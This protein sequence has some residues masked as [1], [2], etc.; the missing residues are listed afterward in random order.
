VE[1]T[2]PDAGNDLEY[3]IRSGNSLGTFGIN[4][5]D[6]GS[7]FVANANA[8]DF[9]QQASYNLSVVLTDGSLETLIQVTVYIN[10]L[11]DVEIT[12]L[13]GNVTMR[14]RGGEIIIITGK[15][16]GPTSAKR[17]VPNITATY[18]T[19]FAT[20]CIIIQRNVK[21][22]CLSSQ[23]IGLGHR[24]IITVNGQSSP[25]SQQT[26]RY[27]QPSIIDVSTAAPLSTQGGENI[28]I[29]ADD[30]GPKG[31]FVKLVYAQ[32]VWAEQLWYRSSCQV[33]IAHRA[34]VCVSVVGIGKNLVSR[35]EVGEQFSTFS[36]IEI[37]Y[38][39]PQIYALGGATLMDTGGGE[40]VTI[41]GINF[42][43][44]RIFWELPPP[45]GQGLAPPQPERV[46]A[47]YGPQD[48][49]RQ[50][51][52][53]HCQVEHAHDEVK[54]I[55]TAGVG[56]NHRWVIQIGTGTDVQ[57]SPES[58]NTSAYKRPAISEI[59]GPG[60]TGGSTAGGQDFW[61]HGDNLGPS[62]TARGSS[63]SSCH[64]SFVG[65]RNR[66][67]LLHDTTTILLLEGDQ[68]SR[69]FLLFEHPQ[70]HH[71]RH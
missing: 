40:A 62:K 9:E 24:W 21:V 23:G 4:A 12:G 61:I 42:G 63:G 29:R 16:F 44:T 2:D 56:K 17:P 8:L 43:P 19:Y 49:P 28:T 69:F 3:Y 20:D 50:F 14:T 1:A 22:Q 52:A 48:N 7:L 6:G 33:T 37:A 34:A 67:R 57:S 51:E 30:I 47:F 60:V 55:T 65:R 66:F 38:G 70:G 13:G 32:R 18:G 46:R 64:L 15:N 68:S 39:L 41:R 58:S 54:C 36:E 31:S 71:L 5:N 59:S 10:D 11:N 35:V 25:P 53:S 26:T 45:L 27:Y